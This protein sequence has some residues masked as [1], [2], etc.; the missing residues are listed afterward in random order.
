VVYFP[1]SGSNGSSYHIYDTISI[2]A[3]VRLVTGMDAAG[4]STDSNAVLIVKD[5]SPNAL[6]V[7]RIGLGRIRNVCGRTLVLRHMG[8]GNFENG[9]TCGE[10]YLEDVAGKLTPR[11]P[12]SLWARQLNTEVQPES[13]TNV[14]NAGG[15]HWILGQKTEGR[16]PISITTSGGCT[17]ILGGLMYPASSFAVGDSL[18][19]AFVSTDACMSVIMAMS[20]YVARGIYPVFARE[21]R[22]AQTR[23]LKTSDVE[24]RNGFYRGGCD[25]PVQGVARQAGKTPTARPAVRVTSAGILVSAASVGEALMVGIDGRVLRRTRLAG[26]VGALLDPAGLAPGAYLVVVQTADARRVE[27][28]VVGR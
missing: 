24:W 20:S 4:I 17:E 12:V 6:I 28:L 3:T 13:D 1:P 18:S 19:P 11:Y 2:P 25:N 22:S 10:L 16:A 5:D 8:I 23:T 14:L 27:R 21:T 9:P 26:G 15:M 7:E